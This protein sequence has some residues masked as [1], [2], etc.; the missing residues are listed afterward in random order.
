MIR[1]T[2]FL[3]L[4][5]ATESWVLNRAN[6]PARTLSSFPLRSFNDN[7]ERYK[8]AEWPR[9]PPKFTS[10]EQEPPMLMVLRD[11]K[12][13]PDGWRLAEKEEAQA[14]RKELVEAFDD[15]E[16][17]RLADDWKIDGPCYGGLI[18]KGEGEEELDCQIITPNS[19]RSISNYWQ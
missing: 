5:L 16:I 6:V 9:E 8:E 15:W 7:W 4:L 12:P 1:F 13:V 17:C 14:R 18:Q 2:L 10:N 11:H 3:S 19:N